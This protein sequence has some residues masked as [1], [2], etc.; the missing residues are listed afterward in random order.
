MSLGLTLKQV[1]LITKKVRSRASTY[2]VRG[3][4]CS[5]TRSF[6]QTFR[7]AKDLSCH[8]KVKSFWQLNLSVKQERTLTQLIGQ[9][10][11]KVRHCKPHLNTQVGLQQELQPAEK[12]TIFFAL[13]YKGHNVY[14]LNIL[15]RVKSKLEGRDNTSTTITVEE[16]VWP[17]NAH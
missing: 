13:N 4:I 7:F 16:Q 3:R 5:L 8:T 14:A 10:A 12:V 15:Q 17:I 9:Q 1:M 11:K 2:F 6:Y